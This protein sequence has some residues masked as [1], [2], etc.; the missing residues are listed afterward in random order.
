MTFGPNDTFTV[1]DG[2]D[3]RVVLGPIIGPKD[4]I[5]TRPTNSSSVKIIIGANDAPFAPRRYAFFYKQVP[6]GKVTLNK[7]YNLA[8]TLPYLSL[9]YITLPYLASPHLILLYL[10]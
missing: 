10:S 1:Y 8:V 2:K 4:W 9:S 5:Q 7:I 3:N 6:K